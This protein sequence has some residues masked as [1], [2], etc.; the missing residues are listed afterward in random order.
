M[1]SL[2]HHRP[3]G[4][5]LE[6][7]LTK[8]KSVDAIFYFKCLV[9]FCLIFNCRSTG[10]LSEVSSM[11]FYS[12]MTSL[13]FYFTYFNTRAGSFTHF[14][15]I[16]FM[17]NLSVGRD[18]AIYRFS[19]CWVHLDRTCREDLDPFHGEIEHLGSI[20]TVSISSPNHLSKSSRGHKIH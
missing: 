14:V 10:N 11:Y 20:W 17:A 6:N 3:Q 5:P 8:T 13:G 16:N 12:L 7:P 4:M 15:Y 2:Q 18:L 19:C 9:S 1:T